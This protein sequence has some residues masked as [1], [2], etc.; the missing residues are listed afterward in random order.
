[1][2]PINPSSAYTRST[3]FVSEE[4]DAYF[5]AD[6]STPVT[7][8]EGGWRGILYANLAIINPRA[9]WAFF[10]QANFDPAWLDGGASRTWYLAYAA[11]EQ[12]F[13]SLS[14]SVLYSQSS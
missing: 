4:W 8:V 11:G 2:I 14:N 13:F 3:R 1:M 9:S 6:G 7:T 5:D 12:F 10:A